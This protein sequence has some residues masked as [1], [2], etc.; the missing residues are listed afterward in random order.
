[1]I[2]CT[3]KGG[4]YVAALCLQV[5]DLL[6]A[7][8]MNIVT[9]TLQALPCSCCEFKTADPPIRTLSRFLS[10]NTNLLIFCLR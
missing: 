6:N 7:R 3:F 2:D 8:Y 4:M 5:A 9:V 1:M 10:A